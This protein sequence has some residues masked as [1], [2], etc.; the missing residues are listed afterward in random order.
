MP[1]KYQI[2]RHAERIHMYY[3]SHPEGPAPS[4]TLKY[5]SQ[6]N[7]PLVIITNRTKATIRSRKV[8]PS[9]PKMPWD[10]ETST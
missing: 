6:Q 4:P 7:T 1:N 2:R 3:H 10:T 5:T 8:K 9:M